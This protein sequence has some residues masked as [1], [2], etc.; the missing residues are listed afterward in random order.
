MDTKSERLLKLEKIFNKHKVDKPELLKYGLSLGDFLR[1]VKEYEQLP[2]QKVGEEEIEKML[3]HFCAAANHEIEYFM[4]WYRSASLSGGEKEA[5]ERYDKAF[6]YLWK[7]GFTS[8]NREGWWPEVD[9]ALHMS[10]G[11][12]QTESKT[13]K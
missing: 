12:D 4:K 8:Y 6:D 2:E 13:E 11:L 1:A 7:L 3:R 5:Q 9:E 10:A